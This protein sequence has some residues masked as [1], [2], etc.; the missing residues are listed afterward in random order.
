MPISSSSREVIYNTKVKNSD[1]IFDHI[2]KISCHYK[3][4]PFYSETLLEKWY[5]GIENQGS[6][7]EITVKMLKNICHTLDF[8]PN[9]RLASSIVGRVQARGVTNL[10][11]IAKNT[12]AD[13][14]ISG[15]NG[16]EYGILQAFANHKIKVLFH[17][18]EP[19]KYQHKGESE[20]YP[21]LAFPDIV[22]NLGIDE[23][24]QIIRKKPVLNEE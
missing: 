18:W 11:D 5:S 19:V 23:V 12:G 17:D 8:D 15:P 22:F 14:Y 20:F 24:K 3:E 1:W 10:V 6:F 7:L 2:N 21:Y 4:H 13:L 9:I 16:R